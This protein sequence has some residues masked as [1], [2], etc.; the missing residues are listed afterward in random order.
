LNAS[1]LVALQCS[2]HGCGDAERCF[3][4]FSEVSAAKSF[5]CHVINIR[6]PTRDQ[7][8]RIDRRQRLARYF[9]SC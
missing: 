7:A 2:K 5:D 1:K 4:P 8:K 3:V 6:A 9:F